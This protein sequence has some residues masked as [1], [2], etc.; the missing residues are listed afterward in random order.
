M[1]SSD[2]SGRPC[3]SVKC[4]QQ[5]EEH[6]QIRCTSFL[7]SS[8]YS[9][10]SWPSASLLLHLEKDSGYIQ[11]LLSCSCYCSVHVQAWTVHKW[12]QICQH[13]G[14]AFGNEFLSEPM[15][16]GWLYCL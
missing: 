16:C 6:L 8:S 11:S 3:I 9:S 14:L 13:R 12:K 2:Y 5:E 4:W 7:P 10:I 15:F 1:L